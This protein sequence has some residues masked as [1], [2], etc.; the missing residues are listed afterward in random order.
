MVSSLKNSTSAILLP[1]RNSRQRFAVQSHR[2][3]HKTFIQIQTF[4]RCHEN[5]IDVDSGPPKVNKNPEMGQMGGGDFGCRFEFQVMETSA[6]FLSSLAAKGMCFWK[7]GLY[8]LSDFSS[9]S[10]R[11]SLKVL[12]TSYAFC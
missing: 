4:K 2:V 12:G 6:T 10:A 5:G 11:M 3:S 9:C 7:C 1:R 8:I